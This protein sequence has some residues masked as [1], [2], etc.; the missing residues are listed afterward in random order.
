M[1][2]VSQVI[3]VPK[4]KYYESFSMVFS[5]VFPI[6]DTF[7]AQY[8]RQMLQ[9]IGIFCAALYQ[10]ELKKEKAMIVDRNKETEKDKRKGKNSDSYLSK[11]TILKVYLP[12]VYIQ[13]DGDT[14]GSFYFEFSKLKSEFRTIESNSDSTNDEE[15]NSNSNEN[16]ET[17]LFINKIKLI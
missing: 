17:V 10:I 16:N 13:L 9:N 4:H 12:D 2:Y 3:Y 11:H 1:I 8:N 7:F 6:F 14:I 5:M 15:R